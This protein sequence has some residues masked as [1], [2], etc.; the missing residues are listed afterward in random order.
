MLYGDCENARVP[1]SL[2]TSIFASN[3]SLVDTGPTRQKQKPRR[4]GVCVFTTQL[5]VEEYST[6]Q[7]AAAIP[8]SILFEAAQCTA[9]LFAAN[10]AFFGSVSSSTPSLYLAWTVASSTS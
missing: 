1:C 4:S 7:T 5:L 8:R 2:R 3:T 6:S 9:I 10:T